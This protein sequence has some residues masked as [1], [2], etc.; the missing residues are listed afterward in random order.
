MPPPAE[1]VYDVVFDGIDAADGQRK[2]LLWRDGS[3]TAQV[4]GAGYAGAGAAPR[5]DG[6]AL[7]FHSIATDTEPS[8]LMLADDFSKPA[9]FFAGGGGASEREPDWSPDAQRVVYVSLL[10]DPAGDVFV[11]DVSAGRLDNM[12]NLTPCKICGVVPE[13]EVTPTWSPDGRR[14]AYTSYE[15]LGPAIWV[16][17]ADGSNAVAVTQ[18]GGDHGDFHPSWSPDGTRIAFQRNSAQ[19]TRIGIVTVGNGQTQWFDLSGTAHSPAWSPDGNRIA[20][21]SS[22]GGADADVVIMD[23]SGH[24]LARL[25]RAGDDYRPAWLR[26]SGS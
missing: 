11:A 23:T 18:A 5:D 2:I 1:T 26:R 16:M 4:L 9:A 25:Q 24:E 17:D 6:R 22:I 15:G 14:I 13:S 20:Y 12:R 3:A 10:D 21:V 7:I 8:A 19:P